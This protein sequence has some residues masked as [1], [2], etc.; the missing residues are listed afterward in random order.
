M[1][2]CIKTKWVEDPEGGF[3]TCS[4]A[5]A[6]DYWYCLNKQ[7]D[8][9]ES[10]ESIETHIKDQ[11]IRDLLGFDPGPH[12]TVIESCLRL[13]CA[14]SGSTPDEDAIEAI[15]EMRNALARYGVYRDLEHKEE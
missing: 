14:I 10:R 9:E 1:W 12:L 11:I 4:G 6:R 3:I 5:L 8:N 7:C 15:Q 13:S 2:N